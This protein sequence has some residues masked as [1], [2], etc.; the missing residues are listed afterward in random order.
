MTKSF[1][2]TRI[3]MIYVYY[4]ELVRDKKCNIARGALPNS[5]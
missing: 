3:N 5:R 4:L 1:K 2:H